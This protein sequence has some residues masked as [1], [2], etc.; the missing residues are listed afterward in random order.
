MDDF[1]H[2]IEKVWNNLPIVV[3]AAAAAVRVIPEGSAGSKLEK[4]RKGLE[5]LALQMRPHPK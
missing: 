3:A 4:L 1:A 5:F 2:V